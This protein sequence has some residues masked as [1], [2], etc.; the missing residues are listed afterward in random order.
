MRPAILVSLLLCSCVSSSIELGEEP[1]DAGPQADA[2]PADTGPPEPDTEPPIQV[3]C[4]KPTDCY[5]TTDCCPECGPVRGA[6][7]SLSHLAMEARPSPPACDTVSCMCDSEYSDPTLIPDCVD[8]FCTFIDL[9]EPGDLNECDPTLDGIECA[10]RLGDCCE[11]GTPEEESLIAIHITE[12]DAYREHVC[13]EEQ[14]CD[15]PRPDY[16]TFGFEP[17]CELF[18]GAPRCVFYRSDL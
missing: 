16:A 6:I 8:N 13:T 15:C 2:G 7:L 10:V 1:T 3:E 4:F 17:A 18:E 5:L 11:C 9:E 12:E 14:E